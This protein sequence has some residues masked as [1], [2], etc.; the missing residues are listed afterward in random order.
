MKNHELVNQPQEL[1]NTNFLLLLA[2]P[3][4][5]GKDTVLDAFC[6]SYPWV[7][8]IVSYTT[9][10]IS[11]Q[12]IEGV[13]YHFVDNDKFDLITESLAFIAERDINDRHIRYGVHIDDLLA[14]SNGGAYICHLDLASLAGFSQSIISL[15]VDQ[16]LVETCI[17]KT[18]PIFLGVPRLTILKDRCYSRH[19][20]GDTKQVFLKRLGHEFEAWQEFKSQIPNVI[21]N[22]CPLPETV[23]QIVALLNLQNT[24][25]NINYQSN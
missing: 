8:R 9:K 23:K 24:L 13:T 2:G 6:T 7:N 1:H 11:S 17:Q 21:M 5:S 4:T 25:E 20:D 19:R 14:V 18:V 3:T 22:C 12:D 16:N 15:P 10:P